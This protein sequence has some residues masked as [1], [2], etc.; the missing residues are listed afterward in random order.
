MNQA[1]TGNTPN[2]NRRAPPRRLYPALPNPRPPPR[3]AARVS[4]RAAFALA[5]YPSQGRFRA[6]LNEIK[7]G[8]P[9]TTPTRLELINTR[10]RFTVPIPTGMNRPPAIM[11]HPC[12][13]ISHLMV[14]NPAW[15]SIDFKTWSRSGD[16]KGYQWDWVGD[17]TRPP[18]GSGVDIAP[19]ALTDSNFSAAEA[20][21]VPSTLISPL[22][23]VTGGLLT[24]RITCGPGTTGYFAFSCPALSEVEATNAVVDLYAA[25]STNPRIRRH[26]LV[27]GTQTHH[28]IAPITNGPALET[29]REA[30]DRFHWGG[31]DPFGATLITF[32]DIHYN[33]HLGVAPVVELYSTVGLQCR[34]EIA[35][36]HLATNHHIS[37]KEKKVEHGTGDGSGHVGQSKDGHQQ[38]VNESQKADASH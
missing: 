25:H 37:S 35:D 29:F 28:F 21:G 31:E 14:F 19:R 2:R 13:S 1:T 5:T 17:E 24:M 36:R 26:E 34:L 4:R 33:T 15:P 11:F 10:Q 22:T 9:F 38:H 32:H 6:V 7:R 20:V 3:Q 27:Q 8:L 23:R 16:T 30:N 12:R 18:I